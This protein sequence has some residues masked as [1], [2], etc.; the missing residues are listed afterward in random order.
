MLAQWSF[1]KAGHTRQHPLKDVENLFEEIWAWSP[2][3]GTPK[4]R[5]SHAVMW[6]V[7]LQ[8]RIHPR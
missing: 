2:V 4:T 1:P 7:V 3:M 8:G 6:E 5:P